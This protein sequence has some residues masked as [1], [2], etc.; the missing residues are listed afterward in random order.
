VRRVRRLALSLAALFALT[1]AAMRSPL[2][3]RATGRIGAPAWPYLPGSVVPLRVQ[4]FA[5]P[6]DAVLLGPGHLVPG[7]TYEIPPDAGAGSALLIAGNRAG[8]AAATV[9]IA[10]PPAASRALVVVASYDEGLVF[11]DARDFSVLGVLATGGAPGDV[12]IDAHGSVAAPDTEGSALAL[13]SLRPWNVARVDG[14]ALGDQVAIDRTTRAIFVTDRDAG[15]TGA[16]TRVS[17]DGTITRTPTG[18]TAEGLVVDDRRQVVYVA[19]TND[20]SVTEIDARSMRRLRRFRA[21]DRVFSLALSSDGNLLYGIS[22]Q[23]ASSLFDAPGSAI[24][25][26]TGDVRPRLVARS[27]HLTF[28]LGV[29]LDSRTRT[30]FVTDESTAQVDV[31]DARTLREKHLPLQTCAIPWKPTLD[32]ASERLYVPCAGANRIDAFDARTLQRVAG[33]PFATGSYP[34][35]V[36]V[37]HPA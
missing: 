20:G 28:P 22:N 8:L 5:P 36:A 17:D 32:D 19:N 24:A 30:L 15:G 25:L 37:W 23:S 14:V 6:Y 2:E 12:A 35:A 29:A 18:A 31:L 27:A 33:A 10:P 3:E 4:G 34:L 11:H 13:A 9:R 1:A 16:L 7:G 26:A 21:V